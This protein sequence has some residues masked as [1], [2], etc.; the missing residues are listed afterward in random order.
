MLPG[1]TKAVWGAQGVD[2]NKPSTVPSGPYWSHWNLKCHSGVL[3][4]P[5]DLRAYLG[6][7]QFPDISCMA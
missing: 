7:L 3:L 4:E 6:Q 5:R 2:I 1:V